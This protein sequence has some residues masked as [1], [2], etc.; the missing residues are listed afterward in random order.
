M[1]GFEKCICDIEKK[2]LHEGWKKPRANN[3]QNK[4]KINFFNLILRFF[5]LWTDMFFGS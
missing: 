3:K 2:E 1:E 4:K 5:N